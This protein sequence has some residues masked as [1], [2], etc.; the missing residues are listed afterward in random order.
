MFILPENSFFG[1]LSLQSCFMLNILTE[2]SF[3]VNYVYNDTII[4][5]LGMSSGKSPSHSASGLTP[6]GDSLGSG[7]GEDIQ[8]SQDSV[9]SMSSM[10]EED[11]LSSM[12]TDW[13]PSEESGRRKS[14]VS[15]FARQIL[16]YKCK[17]RSL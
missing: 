13:T 6:R 14:D 17:L 8:A 15:F 5:F 1:K 9:F 7:L 10:N 2:N 11:S 12:D 16:K 3:L 4:F